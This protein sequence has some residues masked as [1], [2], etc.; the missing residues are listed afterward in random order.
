LR[1][2]TCAPWEESSQ[3]RGSGTARDGRKR[4]ERERERKRGG[5]RPYRPQSCRISFRQLPAVSYHAV[6]KR[7]PRRED[8][9]GKKRSASRDVKLNPPVFEK[10]QTAL[11]SRIAICFYALSI[12]SFPPPRRLLSAVGQVYDLRCGFAFAL[13]VAKF[14][15]QSRTVFSSGSPSGGQP[16]PPLSL[17][18]VTFIVLS[19]LALASEIK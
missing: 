1:R 15:N 19:C 18:R 13:N 11:G 8:G 17:H 6:L 16:R 12:S 5:I 2:D 9:R 4:K 7:S 10:A 3:H 14:F